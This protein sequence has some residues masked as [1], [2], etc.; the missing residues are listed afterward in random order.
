VFGKHPKLKS[1]NMGGGELR[2]GDMRPS[3]H[4]NESTLEDRIYLHHTSLYVMYGS[5]DL[6]MGEFFFFFYA[7]VF[8]RIHGV[9]GRGGGLITF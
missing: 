9:Q 3:E 2:T 5:S 4:Y 1:H 8:G 6:S 7:F